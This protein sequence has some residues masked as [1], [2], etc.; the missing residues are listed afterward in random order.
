MGC[1]I[2]KY[3]LNFKNYDSQI[4]EIRKSIGLE[5]CKKTILFAP[6]WDP[7]LKVLRTHG[8]KLR[9]NLFENLK[10]YNF[11]INLQSSLH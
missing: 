5:P 10:E 2:L 3:D 11:I 8:L 7:K 9:S 1:R 4:E 6:A